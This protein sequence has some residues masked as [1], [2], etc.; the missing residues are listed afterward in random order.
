MAATTATVELA[1]QQM[2][3]ASKALGKAQGHVDEAGRSLGG[4]IQHESNVPITINKI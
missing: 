1:K 3:F 2:E 4:A